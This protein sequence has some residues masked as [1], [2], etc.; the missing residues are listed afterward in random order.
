[1]LPKRCCT[2]KYTSK[3]YST[4]VNVVMY[5]FLNA[6][7]VLYLGS[8]SSMLANRLSYFFNLHGESVT[9]DCAC[10]SSLMAVQLGARSIVTGASK[11]ALCGG[12]NT[13][14]SPSTFVSLSKANM[15]S[16][17]GQCHSFSVE[18]DGYARSE[19]C[20]VVLL[21]NLQQ[22]CNSSHSLRAHVNVLTNQGRL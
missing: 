11:M 4:S 12:V 21:K 20:G 5:F 16:A 18:A 17:K 13:V 8:A 3:F 1:M 9:I 10:S 7:L 22:V 6:W 14:L 19:G 2:R 15:A